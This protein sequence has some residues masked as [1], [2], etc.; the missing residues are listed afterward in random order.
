M[1]MALSLVTSSCWFQKAKTSRVFVPPPAR[2]RPPLATKVAELPP[3]PEIDAPTVEIPLD[4][5]SPGGLLANLPPAGAPPVAPP[6][7]QPPKARVNPP[8]TPPGPEP[9][10]P[11]KLGQI[12]TADQLRDNNRIIDESSETV[13]RLLARV[14]GKNLNAEQS[15]DLNR[16]QT[17]QKQ[18]EQARESDL[19]T[20]VNLARRADLLAQD[21]VK[22]LP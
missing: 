1:L 15:D 22:R 17:F 9:P 21:L 4:Q 19:V 12:F 20:A 5:E 2:P 7:V 10:P 11:P 14:A 6:K 13:K 16:I 8:P 3:A 18:A